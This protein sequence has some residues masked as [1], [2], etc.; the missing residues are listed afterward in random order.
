[1]VSVATTK[2]SCTAD[3][4]IPVPAWCA[5][6]ALKMSTIVIEADYGTHTQP[7][8]RAKL[9]QATAAYCTVPVDIKLSVSA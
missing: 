9:R 5:G 6:W 7:A 8:V 4:K 2:H 1:M 3:V